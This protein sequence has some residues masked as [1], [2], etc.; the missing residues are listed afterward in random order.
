VQVCPTGIDIRNGLQY[1]C[2]GCAACI[3]VCDEVMEKVGYPKGL[4]RYTTERALEGGQT[5]ILRPRILVYSAGL[6]LITVALIV[7]V[8]LRTP[9]ELDILRDRNA[10]YNETS[11]GWI[12]N[13]Y[14][15]KL[16]NMVDKAQRFRVTVAGP[17]SLKLV[18]AEGNELLVESGGVRAVP[19]TLL[20]DPADLTERSTKIEFTMESID[21]PSVRITRVGRFLGPAQAPG[22]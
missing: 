18:S 1:Q 6:L 17:A 13:V 16:I 10:L 21:D 5:K 12:E 15:L 2:I 22:R 14:T 20:A 4:V 3:D 19:V 7:A 9:I 8:V 11:Q